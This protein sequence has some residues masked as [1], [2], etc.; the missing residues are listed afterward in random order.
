MRCRCILCKKEIAPKVFTSGL[1]SDWSTKDKTR[2]SYVICPYC[3]MMFIHPLP[4]AS[5]LKKE[6]YNK[7]YFQW[8]KIKW[9][10]KIIYSFYLYKDYK[11]WVGKSTKERKKILDLGAGEGDFLQE[12]KNL[13]W[14]VYGTELNPYLKKEMSERFG[15]DRIFSPQDKAFHK[16]YHNFFDCITLWHVV[17]HLENPVTVLLEARNLLKKKGEI[18]IEVPNADSLVFAIFKSHYTWLRIPD[19]VTYYTPRTLKALLTKTGFSHGDFS[20]P[21]K[22]NLNFSLSLLSVMQKK[23]YYSLI[24]RITFFLSIPLSIIISLIAS[25]TGRSE[26]V[27]VRA[28]K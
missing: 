28:K 8:K 6:V 7:N 19:H 23:N 18:F 10:Q 15:K 26:V 12:M 20:Y 17:E 22:A 3:S 14:E 21:L 27:R 5:Q 1:L 25:S 2:Y 4:K 9:Y 11:T 13:G 16:R 24:T